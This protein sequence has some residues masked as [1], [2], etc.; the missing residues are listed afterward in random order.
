MLKTALRTL[1]LALALL[2]PGAGGQAAPP[3]YVVGVE[4]HD[5]YPAYGVLANGQYG[6]AARLILD[7]FAADQGIRLVYRPL[8]VKRLYAELAGGGIDFKFPDSPDWNPPAKQGITVAYSKPVIRY[9]DGTMVLPANRGKPVATLGTISGFTPFAWLGRVEAG[10]VQV[11]EAAGLDL[12]LNQVIKGRVDG[13]YASVA[14]S[15]YRLGSVLGQPGA[16]AFDPGQPHTRDAYL[17]SSAKHPQLIAAFDAWL[18]ANAA[19]VRAIIA[20]TGAEA[21]ID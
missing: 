12:L 4:N 21:G 9:V 10:A 5:Y 14:V 1:A 11:R 19:T 20:E 3:E 15:H 13:G 6:G 2:A 7:R 16:L 8:P 18:A 17:L